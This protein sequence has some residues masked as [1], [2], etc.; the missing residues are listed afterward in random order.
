MQKIHLDTDLGGDIDDL[1]AFAMLLRWSEDVHLIGI[2]TVAETNGRRAGYV[3]Y[4]LGL[5]GRSD[6]PVAAGADVAGGFYRYPELGYPDEQRYWPERIVPAP[7]PLDDAI[8]LLKQS[9]EKGATIIAIGPYT[10]LY[11]LDLQYPGILMKAELFLMGGYIYP[12]RSGFPQWGNE[13]DW[14]IQLDLKSAKHVIENS[15]PTLIPLTVTVETALRRVYV[16]DLRK[17]GALGQLIARQAEAFAIDEQNESR[18]GET[19]EGLPRDIINFQHDPLACA[20]A[21]GWNAGVEIEELSLILE[22]KDGW[23]HEH[24]H[25]YGKS[26]RVVTKVNGPRFSEFW[27]N[28]IVNR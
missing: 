20:I 23:L 27:I 16:E 9:I 22:E 2:T 19:C 11:L 18:F 15:N 12:V 17:S 1:C 26:V 8:Q 13:M 21:L 6:I 3:R 7:N 24:I 14:N 4:V 10:N 25:S 28:K 5:E